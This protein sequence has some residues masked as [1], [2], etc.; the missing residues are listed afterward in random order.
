MAVAVSHSGLKIA[1][2]YAV[3]A[4]VRLYLFILFI[5]RTT[6]PTVFQSKEM[7][8]PTELSDDDTDEEDF[9]GVQVIDDNSRGTSSEDGDYGI[10]VGT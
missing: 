3:Q 10:G 5:L 7:D 9:E 6:F 2:T 8:G 4:L 1:G